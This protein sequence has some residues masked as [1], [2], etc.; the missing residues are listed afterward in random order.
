MIS[1]GKT[2]LA[3]Q[4]LGAIGDRRLGRGS[5][6]LG[7]A[8]IAMGTSCTLVG[9]GGGGSGSTTIKSV[10][11]TPTSVTVPINTQAD[12]TATV[13]LTDSTTSSTTTVTWEVNGVSGGNSTV[14]TIV[15]S[16]TDELVGIYTAPSAVP[17]TSSGSGEQVGQVNITAVATQGTSSSTSSSGTVT[18]NTAIVTVSVGLGLSVSP[19]SAIVPAGGTSQFTA[20][21]NSVQTAA[22]WALSST[23][24]SGGN[25][26]TIDATGLYTAPA[27]PP[28]GNSITVTA[29][30]TGSNGAVVTATSTLSVFYSDHSLSGPYAFSYTGNDASGYLAVAGSFVADGSG[31]IVSGIEDIESFLSGVST[32][33]QISGTYSVGSDG[34]GTVSLTRGRETNTW[35]FA[36]TSNQ[37]AQLTRFDT[38]EAA[39]GTIDQQS[40]NGLTTSPSL[41]S[42]RY[43][44]SVLGLDASFNPLGMAGE[45][46]ADGSGGVSNTNAI[47]DVNDNS[48]SGGTVT[49]G[50]TTLNGSYS[51]DSVNAGT[52]RG[53][54]TLQS[55]PTGGTARKYA[56]YTVGTT[57]NS[58]N[59]TV[60][61]QLHLVEIDGSAVASVAGDMFFVGTSPVSVLADANYVFT[62]G[63]NSSAGAYA[64][65]GVFASDGVGTTSNGTLDINNAGTYNK[66]VSLGSCA[67][68]SNPATGRIDLELCP[69]G[70]SA[71]EFAAYPTALGNVVL[72]E[73]DSSA[74]ATGLAYQQCGPQSAGCAAASP[75]L[76]AAAVSLGLVGQG[77]FRNP[78][79][80]AASFQPDLDGQIELT[81]TAASTGNLDINNF[82]AVFQSDP[83]GA[84]GT[85]IGAASN[86]RGTA[87]LA[88][89]NPSATY[90]LVFYLIDDHD[91]LLLSSGQSPVAIGQLGR[92]F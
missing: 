58:A 68:T 64:S 38:S 11:I 67:F 90:N 35:E 49:K 24:G 78:P 23:S 1:I 65:G 69:S 6:L 5:R 27:F 46:S 52:G 10:A 28:P 70:A 18:S 17:T 22:S 77:L 19:T 32:Q 8:L 57:T 14:G 43:A 59:A 84:T 37:H 12:F 7:L 45:F 51:F 92:Q 55:A 85:S 54:I 63:G 75:D 60:V 61:S 86:G 47:L 88:P 3:P 89:T 36:L 29:S 2:A 87:T 53:T 13:T 56:F 25:L 31:H 79:A 91:A 62:G 40:L 44:F 9:C 21:L 48:I 4:S 71:S 20:I 30:V 83:I 80:T 73:L 72:L 76:S 66:G 16:T 41:I 39:G 15:P 33:V 50:D 81:G 34:R 82:N 42:G 26:G 74:V